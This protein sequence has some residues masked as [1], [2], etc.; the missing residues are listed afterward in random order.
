MNTV[1]HYI[2]I[3]IAVLKDFRTFGHAILCNTILY[4]RATCEVAL[5]LWDEF[6]PKQLL[7]HTPNPSLPAYQHDIEESRTLLLLLI[8]TAPVVL[9]L[10]TVW[11]LYMAVFIGA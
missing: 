8:I 7:E 2:H 5:E 11:F 1:S 10:G 4:G 6:A 9:C 3:C